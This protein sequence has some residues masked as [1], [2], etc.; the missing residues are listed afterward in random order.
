MELDKF[1]Q[2]KSECVGLRN[3]IRNHSHYGPCLNGSKYQDFCEKNNTLDKCIN[4][5]DDAIK[6]REKI[7]E[8]KI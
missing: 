6:L 8:K 7:I 4:I 3:S 1:Y 5:I 2:K